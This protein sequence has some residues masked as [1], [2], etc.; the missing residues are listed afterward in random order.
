MQDAD[1]DALHQL[2]L[3]ARKHRL[4]EPDYDGDSP[5]TFVIRALRVFAAELGIDLEGKQTDQD[6]QTDLL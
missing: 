2:A 4:P 1:F 3:L 6:E 5:G